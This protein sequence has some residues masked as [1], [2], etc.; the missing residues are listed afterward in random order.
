[1][2]DSKKLKKS[3]YELPDQKEFV[4]RT[5]REGPRAFLWNL[6]CPKVIFGKAGLG[7]LT[8]M[9]KEQFDEVDQRVL[10]IADP[11]LKKNFW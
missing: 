1:M 6:W 9:L 2:G 3:W 11:F 8:I 7:F 5:S 4:M 10:I